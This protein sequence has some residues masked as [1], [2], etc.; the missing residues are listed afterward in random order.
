MSSKP[1]IV[2]FPGAWHPATTIEPFTQ[3]LRDRGYEAHAH[4]LRSVGNVSAGKAEDIA[5]VRSVL[6]ELIEQGKDVV[7]LCHSFAGVI[8]ACAIEGL[9]KKDRAAQ[10]QTGGLIGVIYMAAFVPSPAL[11]GPNNPP[12]APWWKINVRCHA[13]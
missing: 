1:A 2:A 5:Y 6:L 12:T 13:R 10:G 11:T 3:V 8:C 9:H 7:L 4:Q